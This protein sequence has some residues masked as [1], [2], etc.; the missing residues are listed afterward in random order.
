MEPIF[1][2]YELNNIGIWIILRSRDLVADVDQIEFLIALLLELQG[3]VLADVNP[4]GGI[5]LHSH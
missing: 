5:W 2:K 4:E 1:L 3:L